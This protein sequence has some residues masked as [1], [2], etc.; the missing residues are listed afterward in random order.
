MALAKA[1]TPERHSAASSETRCVCLRSLPLHSL[2]H[3]LQSFFA[4]VLPAAISALGTMT[5]TPSS[6]RCS[7][8]LPSSE[9]AKAWRTVELSTAAATAHVASLAKRFAPPSAIRCGATRPHTSRVNMSPISFF[10]C[11]CVCCKQP[12]LQNYAI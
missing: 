4:E 6:R 12:S 2:H 5:A 1:A 11:S 7:T 10:I 8:R 3:L 9:A